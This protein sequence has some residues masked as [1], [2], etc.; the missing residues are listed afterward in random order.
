MKISRLVEEFSE[1]AEQAQTLTFITRAKELQE[2]VLA[3]IDRFLKTCAVEKQARIAQQS[4]YE[5]NLILGLEFAC[6]SLSSELSM[7][8]ALRD[9]RPG[10][11]WNDL[12]ES[13][14]LLSAAIRAHPSL[15]HVE[16][17]LQKLLTVEHL[18]FPPQAFMSIGSIVRTEECSI[19][20][21]DYRHCDHIVGRPYMGQ[22]CSVICKD[23]EL[24][25]VSLV[26]EPADKRCRVLYFSDQGR[27]RDK[28]TWRLE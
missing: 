24:R 22:M 11:A 16:N 27:K 10:D 28:L 18:L 1:V 20:G 4:E 7:Y 15:Q 2:E 23:I 12:V 5:A 25:E 3:V 9:D 26:D 6:R 13:Q 21:Q 8:L 17:N 14:T 19:C